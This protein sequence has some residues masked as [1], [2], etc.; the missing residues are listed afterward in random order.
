MMATAQDD[1]V[2]L[3]LQ[4]IR[5]LRA[6]VLARQSHVEMPYVEMYHRD[7]DGLQAAGHNVD[8]YRIPAGWLVSR[9]V[10]DIYRGTGHR[11]HLS[12]DARFMRARVDSLLAA[13]SK[14]PVTA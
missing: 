1:E 6:G 4:G 14:H 3:S 9:N 8:G 11:S 13:L 12:V 10:I 2:G 7:L 5:A